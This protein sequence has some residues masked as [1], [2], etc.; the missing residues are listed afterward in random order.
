MFLEV[1]IMVVY[2][3]PQNLSTIFFD[4]DST[5]YTNS[6][7]AHAQNAVQIQ[8]FANIK[9]LDIKAAKEMI[10]SYRA[11]W[12]KLHQGKS[13]SLANAMVDFGVSIEESISWRK[14]LIIPED[15]LKEDTE[16]QKIL[17]QLKQS[18]TL[19]CIT[20]NPVSIGRRTLEALGVDQY[21]N[22]I[23]GL[24]TSRV[25]KPDR[26][27]FELALKRAGCPALE[28]LSVGDR[29]TID[30]EIPLEMG[31]GGILVDTVQDV[32]QIPTVLK[33]SQ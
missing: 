12:A 6:Q 30:L 4:I 5:L 2:K 18:Y 16:L 10:D 27:P 28:C 19:M 11:E 22:E 9:G 31:M 1:L 17:H 14:E 7:Y 8:R 26:K 21:I 15:F 23:I 33:L 24:D 32:Y 25:S 29:Y 20:N 13:I 3:I